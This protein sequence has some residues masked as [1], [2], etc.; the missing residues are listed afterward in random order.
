M[1]A[2]LISHT[3]ETHC[4]L[5]L[6][7]NVSERTTPEAGIVPLHLMPPAFFAGVG[8]FPDL[9]F[10]D[11]TWARRGATLAFVLAFGSLAVPRGAALWPLGEPFFRLAPFSKGAVSGAT[12][13][14]CARGGWTSHALRPR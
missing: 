13:A 4:G 6:L 9:A 7:T 3:W 8:F 14:P 11:A 2:S 10:V 5:S 1:S 12:C